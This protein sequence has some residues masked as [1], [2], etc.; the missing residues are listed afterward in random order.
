MLVMRNVFENIIKTPC[1]AVTRKQITRAQLWKYE[2]KTTR[3]EEEREKCDQDEVA[4]RLVM[5][6]V[7]D[8]IARPLVTR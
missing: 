8:N 6:I 4:M 7:L 2:Y 5:R 1:D 3:K